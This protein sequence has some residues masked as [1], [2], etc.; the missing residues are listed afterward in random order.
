MV[1]RSS[2]GPVRRIITVSD[3]ERYSTRQDDEQRELQYRMAEIQDRA[4]RHA[5]LDRQQAFIQHTGDGSVTAW[6]PETSELT[7]LV[8]YLR[9]LREELE[10]VNRTLAKDSRIRVRLAIS[11]G[12]VEEA[13]QGITGQA[14]IRAALLANSDQLRD[15]LRKAAGHPL[16]V[17]ID[18]RL[19]EDVVQTGRRRL[20]EA[21]YGRVTVLDKRGAEHIAWVTIPGSTRRGM[22][23]AAH[24]PAADGPSP[25][26]A[27]HP[28]APGRARRR[29]A[30]LPVIVALI[31]AAGAIAAA[32][33]TVAPSLFSNSSEPPARSGGP[34]AVS[35]P[36]SAPADPKAPTLPGASSKEPGA[37]TPAQNPKAVTSPLYLSS[38]SPFGT[39]AAALSMN[40]SWT[41]EGANYS[42]SIGYPELCS[43]ADV[44]YNLNGSYRYFIAT[45]GVADGANRNDRSRIVTFD[46]VNG[47]SGAVIGFVNAQYGRSQS[48]KFPVEGITSIRLEIST[49]DGG[50][51]STPSVV[52]WGNARLEGL[53]GSSWRPTALKALG[54]RDSGAGAIVASPLGQRRGRGGMAAWRHGG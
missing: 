48:I 14:V 42:R 50:C 28:G 39:E 21:A 37:P 12:I 45:A 47:Q 32:A 51:F 2:V 17:I 4:A 36:S 6:P 31:G 10:R 29:P 15:A 13:A 54:P 7:L 18:S 44:I 22:P 16:A 26:K 41:I 20:R 35:V 30:P 8:D 3:A 33:V 27:S 24:G 5:G 34:S 53:P 1:T 49:A 46:V 23:A 9:E 11:T 40:G 25:V 38:Q 43:S 19:Y 52:V